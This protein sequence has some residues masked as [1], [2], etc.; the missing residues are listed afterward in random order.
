MIQFIYHFIV[1]NKKHDDNNDDDDN[2]VLTSL[3]IFNIHNMSYKY[4]SQQ[5]ILPFTHGKF[6][7]L[8]Y[9]WSYNF[10]TTEN[11]TSLRRKK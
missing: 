3:F 7:K 1:Y 2:K 6:I 5:R 9:N 11:L 10:A 4:Y 8:A